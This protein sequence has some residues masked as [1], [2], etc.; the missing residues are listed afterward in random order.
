MPAGILMGKKHKF[1]AGWVPLLPPRMGWVY[2]YTE[3]LYL[4]IGTEFGG[5]G[6]R[7][8]GS[9]WEEGALHAVRGLGTFYHHISTRRRSSISSISN[10]SISSSGSNSSSE[11]GRGE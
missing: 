11:R 8:G 2:K 6:R 10:I 4:S 5:R 9:A 7:S 3:I 1:F